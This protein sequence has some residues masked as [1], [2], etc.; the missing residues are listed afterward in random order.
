MLCEP[1]LQRYKSATLISVYYVVF[2]GN[3]HSQ[4]PSVIVIW[5]V[6]G[7]MSLIPNVFAGSKASVSV[8]VSVSSIKSSSMRVTLKH[9]SRVLA[10]RSKFCSS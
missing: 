1:N 9:A 5:V 4:S 8:T 3:E 6:L 2:F 10:V 7:A